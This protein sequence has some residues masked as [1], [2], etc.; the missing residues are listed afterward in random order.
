M[1]ELTREELRIL[2]GNFIVYRDKHCNG[3]AK[4]DIKEFYKKY[5][6]NKHC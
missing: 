4:M 3:W 1:K 5:G 2:I 6:L